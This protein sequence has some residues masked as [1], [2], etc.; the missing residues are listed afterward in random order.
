M[1]IH[2]AQHRLPEGGAAATLAGAED[3][4]V[5]GADV[6]FDAGVVD[7]FESIAEAAD[8]G[9][10]TELLFDGAD[11]RE[12]D[13]PE[14]E[15]LVEE[16]DAVGVL[17]GLRT[18]MA[19]DADFRFLVFLGPAKDELLLRGKLVAGKKAGAVK[20]EE[21]RGGGL[22]EDAA[23][24]IGTD[25]EDGEFFRDAGRATHNLWWQERGQRGGRGETN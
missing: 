22:G 10:K 6:G 5:G 18:E 7:F 15:I 8:E 24:Q 3:A 4:V 2:D 14:I 19:D 20:A 16:G 23:I 12:V 9:E 25:K 21:D 11:G 17:A 13:F 1:L